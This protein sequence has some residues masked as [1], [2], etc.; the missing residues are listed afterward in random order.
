M[1]DVE[2]LARQGI[3]Q[4]SAEQ[5]HYHALAVHQS[6]DALARRLRNTTDRADRLWAATLPPQERGVVQDLSRF[7]ERMVQALE[8]DEP[9]VAHDA[10]EAAL[11]AGLAPD[12]LLDRLAA[13]PGLFVSKTTTTG[14][15]SRT[16][17]T[18]AS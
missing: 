10:L 6:A 12:A 16:S 9:H 15:P 1:A 8:R 7:E 11:G 4:E 5:I 18:P 14:P 3:L 17:A 2:E 13:A